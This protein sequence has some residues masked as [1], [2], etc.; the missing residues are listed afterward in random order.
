MRGVRDRPGD[1]PPRPRPRR[2]P[3]GRRHRPRRRC[4]A[5]PRWPGSAHD[6]GIVGYTLG[7]GLGWLARAHGCACNSVTAIELVTAEG[8]L[9]RTDTR[10]EPELFWALRGGGNA[11][12]SSPRS[13]S[14]STRSTEL[15]GGALLFRGARAQ[16]VFTA[17]RDWTRTVPDEVTSLCRLV[18]PPGGRP[19]SPSLVSSRSRSSATTRRS[20]PLRA[21][22][23]GRRPRSP[24]DAG[25]PDRDPQRP[26]GAERRRLR[27][28]PA[29]R[30]H[31]TARS[32]SSIDHAGGPLVSVE[33]RH[34]GGRAL[35]RQRRATARSTTSKAEFALFAVGLTPDAGRR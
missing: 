8:H 19:R 23:A 10:T 18:S 29:E 14:S 20:P 25:P 33:L 4:T 21:L 1:A 28:P 26:E 3:L 34:L 27:P 13:S 35:P 6:V 32:R 15:H 16:E 5:S 22:A 9:V 12:A 31:R 30:R 24:D 17:W 2:H 7:G 11:S